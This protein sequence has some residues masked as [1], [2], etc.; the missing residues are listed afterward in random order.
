MSILFGEHGRIVA[1]PPTGGGGVACEGI[2]RR[3]LRAAEVLLG[4][5]RDREDPGVPLHASGTPFPVHRGAS[6]GIGRRRDLKGKR[7]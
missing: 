7:R 4:S 2:P 5:L 1:G 3:R 6:T